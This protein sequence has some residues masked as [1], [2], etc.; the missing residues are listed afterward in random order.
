M[1]GERRGAGRWSRRRRPSRTTLSA[2]AARLSL[3]ETLPRRAGAPRGASVRRLR[4]TPARVKAQADAQGLAGEGREESGP[5]RTEPCV[6]P[7]WGKTI[8]WRAGC[9]RSACPVVRP[10]KAGV[11]SRSQTCRGKNRKP[12]SWEGR[13]EGNQG[14]EAP[15]QPHLE[16]ERESSGRN[17]CEREVAPK[18]HSS[19]GRARNCRAKAARLVAARLTRRVAPAGWLATAR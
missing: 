13:P 19:E 16:G 17:D 11:F 4:A 14:P 3:G 15:R 5:P 10:G 12:R 8:N 1:P 6:R 2:S 18:V 9:G 7:L